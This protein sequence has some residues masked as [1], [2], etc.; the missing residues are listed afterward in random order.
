VSEAKKHVVRFIA[1]RLA[2]CQ[3]RAR[4]FLQD[5]NSMALGLAA[6]ERTISAAG[7]AVGHNMLMEAVL[8]GWHTARHPRQAPR[9]ASSG[10]SGQQKD[11]GAVEGIDKRTVL[12]V[13]R[14]RP[15]GAPHA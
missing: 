4:S 10:D 3:R 15:P 8:A 6:N 9:R 13:R 2:R 12:I 14:F 5:L 1:L 11:L 7:L